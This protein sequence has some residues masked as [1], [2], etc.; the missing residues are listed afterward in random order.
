MKYWDSSVSEAMS[1]WSGTNI[2]LAWSNLSRFIR[3]EQTYLGR[4]ILLY[5][6]EVEK[7]TRYGIF[8]GAQQLY[9]PTDRPQAIHFV[10]IKE[11][12]KKKTQTNM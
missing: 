3:T 9:R 7:Y 8:L 12:R 10:D 11:R 1:M 2:A 4:D 5:M 6:V